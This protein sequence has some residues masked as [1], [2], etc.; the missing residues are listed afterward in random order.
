MSNRITNAQRATILSIEHKLGHKFTGTLTNHQAKKFINKHWDELTQSK[1]KDFTT[2][3]RK[4]LDAI[5]KLNTYPYFNPDYSFPK[6]RQEA[7]NIISAL[8]GRRK[9]DAQAEALDSDEF[10]HFDEF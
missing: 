1:K 9:D 2:P 6:T 5:D 10:C 4:Q 7:S 8:T 3:T